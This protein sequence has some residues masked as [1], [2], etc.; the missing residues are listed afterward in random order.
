MQYFKILFNMMY[1]YVLGKTSDIQYY[2]SS[3]FKLRRNIDEQ[4]CDLFS[5]QKEFTIV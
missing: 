4:T 2:L 3:H 1:K 5:F